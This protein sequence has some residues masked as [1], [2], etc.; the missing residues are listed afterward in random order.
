MFW[1]E[2]QF[3][4]QLAVTFFIFHSA[5]MRNLR[6]TL[7]LAWATLLLIKA[8]QTLD[9]TIYCV[10]QH[11]LIQEPGARSTTTTTY[12]H[13][14]KVLW[15]LGLGLGT[16]TTNVRPPHKLQD[17]IVL[18]CWLGAGFTVMRIRGR[19]RRRRSSGLAV[20]NI[21]VYS[22]KTPLVLYVLRHWNGGHSNC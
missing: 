17:F 21:N 13:Q 12:W 16:C 9:V 6:V 3:Q 4:D 14:S 11:W 8:R 1:L 18:A 22:R 2:I 19:R 15:W 10:G 7:M 20:L 5:F